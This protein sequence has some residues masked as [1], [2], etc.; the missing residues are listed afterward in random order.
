MRNPVAA[1][2]SSKAKKIV[3]KNIATE[4]VRLVDRVVPAVVE[5]TT[6]ARRVLVN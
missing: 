1:I 2:I 6:L 5:K 3:V 4:G